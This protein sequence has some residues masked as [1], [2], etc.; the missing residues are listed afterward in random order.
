MKTI[1][2]VRFC[3]AAVALLLFSCK[4]AVNVEEVK[5]EIEEANKRQ[6]EGFAK[7]D[8]AMMT[9]NYAADAVILPQNG[10]M[11]SGSDQIQAFFKEMM[12]MM[13]DFKFQSK[14]FEV[15]GDLA[16]EFGSYTGMFQMPG[17]GA[18]ADTG[19]F[20]TVWKKQANGKWMIAA[21]IFNTDMMPPMPEPMPMK[22]K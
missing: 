11:V 13:S 2:F 17:M 15:S 18:M 8:M 7:K 5:K 20:L 1:F 21:D 22:K 16:Y 4:P 9:A 10:R 14:K 19:K 6:V 3:I 12:G